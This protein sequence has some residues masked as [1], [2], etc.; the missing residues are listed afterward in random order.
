MLTN[1]LSPRGVLRYALTYLAIST[2][3]IGAQA[4]PCVTNLIVDT[5]IFSD[6]E[7]VPSLRLPP[8]RKAVI[9]KRQTTATQQPSSSPP[10]SPMS[11]SSP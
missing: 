10:P 7:Y 1:V 4:E 6:V 9:L 5:D 2:V 11:P 3:G 8:R